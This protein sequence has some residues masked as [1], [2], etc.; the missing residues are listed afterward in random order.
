MSLCLRLAC[1]ALFITTKSIEVFSSQI[2]LHSGIYLGS[3]RPCIWSLLIAL[4]LYRVSLLRLHEGGSNGWDAPRSVRK[5]ALGNDRVLYWQGWNIVGSATTLDSES[6]TLSLWLSH[7][8]EILVTSSLDNLIWIYDLTGN[9]HFLELCFRFYMFL[10]KVSINGRKG[11]LTL[12]CLSCHVCWWLD[13]SG[14]FR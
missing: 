5:G 7:H 10:R 3:T 8:M 2:C 14:A 12:L 13:E 1:D 9:R 11:R 4:T 6:F